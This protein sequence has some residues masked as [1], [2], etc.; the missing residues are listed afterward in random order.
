VHVKAE[1]RKSLFPP[2]KDGEFERPS[3]NN[4][5]IRQQKQPRSWENWGGK[6][7]DDSGTKEKGRRRKKV[8]FLLKRKAETRGP[9]ISEKRGRFSGIPDTRRRS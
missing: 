1:H 8:F 5:G 3:L 4:G 6:S 7:S 2:P 9:F